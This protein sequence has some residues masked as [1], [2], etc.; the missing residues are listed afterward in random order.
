M[1]VS[2]AEM[3]ASYAA[4]PLA[5]HPARGGPGRCMVPVT[6]LDDA[7][8]DQLIGAALAPAGLTPEVP[9]LPSGVEAVRRRAADGDPGCSCSITPADPRLSPRAAWTC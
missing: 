8:H 5:G 3:L 1:T 6:E 4:G 7:A 9:G 2:G